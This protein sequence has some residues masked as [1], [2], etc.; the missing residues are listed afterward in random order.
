MLS[1]HECER[2]T[3]GLLPTSRLHLR[4]GI[5]GDTSYVKRLQAIAATAREVY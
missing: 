4:S 1:R 5:G 3:S 2:Y